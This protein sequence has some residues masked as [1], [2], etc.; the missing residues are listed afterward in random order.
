[1]NSKHLLIG[2]ISFACVASSQFAFAQNW[3]TTV[4]FA[5]V[6]NQGD[7]TYSASATYFFQPLNYGANT[8][9]AEVAFVNRIASVTGQV[10]YRQDENIVDLGS[11]GAFEL[12]AELKQF[13]ATYIYRNANSPHSLSA[14]I[15]Y[16]RIKSD[17][18]SFNRFNEPWFPIYQAP[19]VTI[20]TRTANIYNYAVGYDYYIKDGWTVGADLEL[21]E[22]SSTD[23]TQFRLKTNRLWDLGNSKSV[24]IHAAVSRNE[25][26]WVNS[27]QDEWMLELEGRY[28]FNTKTGIAIGARL[29]EDS[30]SKT[31]T[32]GLNHFFSKN[33]SLAIGYEYIDIDSDVRVFPGGAAGGN[34]TA[35]KTQF[36]FRF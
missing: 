10:N 22:S 16:A 8:P 12:G 29:P 31:Y 17:Q 5:K 15:G 11:A 1:M 3:E 7:P 24:G 27:T 36:G 19:D 25:I 18:I 26:K 32:L 21:E 35:F 30:F 28:Y 6:E 2:A 13:G 33:V 20:Q 4:G 9:W 14:S 34:I 23:A